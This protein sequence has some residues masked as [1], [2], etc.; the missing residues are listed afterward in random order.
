MDYRQ[1]Q[2]FIKVYEKKNITKAAKSLFISQQALSKAI[3]H[4]E[5][6]LGTPLFLRTHTGIE[7]SEYGQR[8]LPYAMASIHHQDEILRT[9]R[10]MKNQNNKTLSFGY[11][12]GMM[13]HFPDDCLSNFM[14]G[15]PDTRFEISSYHDDTY[16]RLRNDTLLN[17]VLSSVDPGNESFTVAYEIKTPT[18]L[19]M[20][21]SHPLNQYEK[22]TFKYL[23]PYPVMQLNLE[24]D[25]NNSLTQML[26]DHGITPVISIDP[27]EQVLSEHFLQRNQA[28]TFFGGNRSL[29]PDWLVCRE[30]DELKLDM[31][32]YLLT[33]N[34]HIP[35]PAEKEFIVYMTGLMKKIYAP[36]SIKT[37]SPVGQTI[38]RHMQRGV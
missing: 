25:Y 23:K 9:M 14:A 17:V 35:F 10:H 34:G 15:H 8:F 4:L 28:V 24:N 2:Y 6:E 29:L 13:V 27:S 16:N 31:H 22:I 12:T 18:W 33:R 21:N 11:G 5:E 38:A 36:E 20:A 26:K 32:F 3:A 7:L 1:L 37:M 30:M 19:M